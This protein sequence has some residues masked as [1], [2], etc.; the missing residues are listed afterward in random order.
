M[1]EASALKDASKGKQ[2]A[3]HNSAILTPFNRSSNINFED[4][5]QYL[6][7]NEFAQE[8][9][10]LILLPG[11]FSSEIQILLHKTTLTNDDP[12]NYEALSYAWGSGDN[13]ARVKIGA[14]G[15][16]RLPVTQNLE[17]ALRHLRY[18]DEPRM[19]WIDAICVNQQ[20]LNERSRQVQRMKD[21]YTKAKRVVVWLGPADD[22]VS[23]AMVLVEEISSKIEVD[24]KLQ[25][26]RPV[27][28]DYTE[29]GWGIV[30]ARPPIDDYQW[31]A[32]KAFFDRSWFERL[33]IWQEICLADQNTAIVQSGLNFILWRDV[34]DAIFCLYYMEII[35]QSVLEKLTQ[36][37][38]IADTD[39][40]SNLAN[41]ASATRSAKCSDKRDRIYALLSLASDIS[42]GISIT[43][44]YTKTTSQVYQEAALAVFKNSMRMDLLMHCEMR[45][46][47][48]D[49]PSWVPDW[50]NQSPPKIFKTHFADSLTRNDVYYLGNGILSVVGIVGVKVAHTVPIHISNEYT[51]EI[52]VVRDLVPINVLDGQYITGG[53]MLDAYCRM[54]C[55]NKFSNTFVPP[56]T[57]LPNFGVSREA[58]RDLIGSRLDLYD[59]TS[60]AES[61]F[62]SV[63]ETID[64][65]SFLTTEY[66][67]IGLGPLEAQVNDRICIIL[68]CPVPLVLRPYMNGQYRI[69]GSSYVHG[70]MNGEALLGPLPAHYQQVFQIEPITGKVYTAYVNHQTSEVQ[71]QDPRHGPLPEYWWSRSHAEE[72]FW[73][74]FVNNKTGEGREN[75]PLLDPRKTHQ[76]LKERG[77]NLTDI[78]LV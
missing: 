58:L 22:Q 67:H 48:L 20:D 15:K 6:P 38:P 59:L 35:N 73:P 5:Y 42:S 43:P 56:R 69:V 4:R 16:D 55:D 14:S 26:M 1:A 18:E 60:A 70:F 62:D 8:I 41:L 23:L 74:W 24:W 37:F 77:V 25:I 63:I 75:P 53:N 3:K 78:E 29:H 34:K 68:G 30:D 66:G 71:V 72:D 10:L 19:L 17:I 45:P 9:R 44:D 36:V 21:I 49:I 51:H 27:L 46:S 39:S 28:E 13:Q 57:E 52:E 12:P 32:L 64:R 2:L 54:L 50:A 76:A 31:E 40:A 7:L 11:S 47:E 61:Y 65:R 33:W